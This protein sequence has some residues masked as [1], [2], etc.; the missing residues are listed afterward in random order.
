LTEV[1]LVHGLWMGAW[2]LGY[3]ARRWRRQ[4]WRT[5]L[6]PYTTTRASLADNAA[7][8]DAF[9]RR[10]S[11]DV[12]HLAGHSL[13]GLVILEMLN[14][15]SRPHG[16]RVLLLG[17]PLGGSHLARQARRWPGAG[18][19]LG[20]A[21]APLGGGAERWPGDVEI[22]LVAGT[23]PLGLGT[24]TGRLHAPG[25]GT[26]ALDETRHPDLADRVEL[27]VTHTSML[28]SPA[29]AQAGLAFLQ[30]G[31]FEADRPAS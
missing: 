5:R 11:A 20:K 25:D 24:L 23:R 3:L 4:G 13:G 7:R 9:C 15:A 8:L 12:Q 14:Q 10:S 21:A 28:W 22:G 19:L 6:F 31:R 16:G 30:N 18:L 17:T 26:V 29:V 27:P 2:T 1:V